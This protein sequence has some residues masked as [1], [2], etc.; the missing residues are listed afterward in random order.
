MELGRREEEEEEEE[1][2]KKEVDWSGGV[3][4]RMAIAAVGV[5]SVNSVRRGRRTL[6]WNEEG[7]EDA[8]IK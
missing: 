2:R 3:E 4:D 5:N 8:N 1:G 7:E 6:I